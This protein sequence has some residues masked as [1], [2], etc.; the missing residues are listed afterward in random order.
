[1]TS[2]ALDGWNENSGIA[3]S[4]MRSGRTWWRIGRKGAQTV[5]FCNPILCDSA[6]FC[7]RCRL[8]KFPVVLASCCAKVA[9][10]MFTIGR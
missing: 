3:S 2:L 9:G 10:S 4:V 6:S 8:L 7:H 5:G 1:M